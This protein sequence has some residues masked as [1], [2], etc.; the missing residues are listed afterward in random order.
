[1]INKILRARWQDQQLVESGLTRNEMT[2]IATIFVQVWQQSNHQR[3]AY[4]KLAIAP[5]A[6]L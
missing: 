4:P 3:I 6:S 1:M 2:E 5:Q